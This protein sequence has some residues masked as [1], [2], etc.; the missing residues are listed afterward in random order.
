M[1][2]NSLITNGIKIVVGSEDYHSID[3]FDL[4]IINTDCIGEPEKVTYFVEVLGKDGL[5]DL[6]EDLTGRVV[7][8]KRK[9]DIKFM[10]V[11]PIS[12]WT[13]F[14]SDF[15]NLFDGQIVKV[16]F[17]DDED[18]YWTGRVSVGALSRKKEKG[19]FSFTITNADPY[20]YKAQK[21]V[22]ERS[23][24]T[25]A[26]I[27]LTNS[28]KVTYPK[29][30]TNKDIIVSRDGVSLSVAGNTTQILYEFPLEYGSNSLTI[31]NNSGSSASVRIEYQ[32]GSL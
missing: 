12:S 17:D 4:A 18:W 13:E 31:T 32:E 3:D 1:L 5:L 10:G 26:T 6:S 19:N 21:T 7:Y 8:K 27:T 14:M 9:I 2:F 15:R 30:S 20:K 28:K 23:I 29:I 22:I 11:K 25:S 16:F 24:S